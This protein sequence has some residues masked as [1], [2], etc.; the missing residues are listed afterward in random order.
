MLHFS[1]SSF[2][3]DR[4]AGALP[5]REQTR[6]RRLLPRRLYRGRHRPDPRLVLHTPRSLDGVVRQTAVQELDRERSRACLRRT[7]DEQ[8]QEELPGP[9]GNGQEVWG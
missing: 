8:T 7:E 3:D 9:F 2:L 4:P 5:F 6:V 1:S